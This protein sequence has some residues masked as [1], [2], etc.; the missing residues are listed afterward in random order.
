MPLSPNQF[1][2]NNFKFAI[3]QPGYENVEFQIQEFSGLG[4]T[5]N[6]QEQYHMSETLRRPGDN[7]NY[8]ELS[9]SIIIDDKLY[10]LEQLHT[11]INWVKN[12]E[13]NTLTEEPFFTG[14]LT[15]YD[16]KNTSFFEFTLENCFFSAFADLNFTTSTTENQNLIMSATVSYDYY[17]VNR[18]AT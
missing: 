2:A 5:I 18:V 11:Y 17:K 12:T 13:N 9:L 14:L 16:L 1:S 6:V 7:A 4:I 8:N 3:S 15:L 10:A